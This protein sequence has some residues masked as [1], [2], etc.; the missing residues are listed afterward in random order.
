MTEPT[1][2]CWEGFYCESGASAGNEIPCP[3]GKYCPQGSYVPES[4]PS[5]TF[6][7]A[8]GGK[9]LSDCWACTGGMYCEGDGLTQPTGDCSGG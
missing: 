4:C 9:K 6:R 7:N 8:T 3:E 1:E 5:G 2:F